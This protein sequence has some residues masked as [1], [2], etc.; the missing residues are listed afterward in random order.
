MIP[1]IALDQWVCFL[2]VNKMKWIVVSCLGLK[3]WD[4]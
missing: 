4:Q 3:L 1:D 2:W